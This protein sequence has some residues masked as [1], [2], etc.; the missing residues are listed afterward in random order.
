MATTT[1]TSPVD[2]ELERSSATPRRIAAAAG[3][4]RMKIRGGRTTT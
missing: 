2:S 3:A 4:S 1:T